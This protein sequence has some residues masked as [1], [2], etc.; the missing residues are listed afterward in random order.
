ME[1]DCTPEHPF[2]D[3][4]GEVEDMEVDCTPEPPFN[5]ENFTRG[6]RVQYIDCQLQV[7][8]LLIRSYK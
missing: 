1:V 7:S 3:T 4:D 8:F 2:N 6:D 5:A